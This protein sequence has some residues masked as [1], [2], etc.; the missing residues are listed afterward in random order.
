MKKVLS[1]AILA[2]AFVASAFAQ[3]STPYINSDFS[4]TFNGLVQYQ[5]EGPNDQKTSTSEA[6]WSNGTDG[7]QQEVYVRRI[8]AGTIPVDFTS[9]D[10]YVNNHLFG[11]HIPENVSRGY[12]QGHPYTYA[13]YT[14][15]NGLGER[16]RFIIV[17]PTEVIWIEQYAPLST[18]DT[19]EYADFETSLNIK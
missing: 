14:D 4:A 2:L 9:S 3:T 12:Y 10:F 11:T 1:L 5:N 13:F 16:V 6:Y 7:V 18:N 15:D 19:Q 8:T 17:S